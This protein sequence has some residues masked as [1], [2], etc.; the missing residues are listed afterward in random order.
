[1]ELILESN[2]INDYLKSDEIIDYHHPHIQ[3]FARTLSRECKTQIE[4]AEKV[5]EYV[6]DQIAHSGDIDASYVTCSAS[7]V[8]AHRHGVCCAKSH[9]LVAVLRSLNIP[10]GLCYQWLIS[11]DDPEE[12]VIHGLNAIYLKEVGRWIRL[13]ARGNRTGI[14]AE[15]SIEEEKLAWPIRA[16]LGEMDDPMIYRA[17]Q[18]KVVQVLTTYKDRH[19]PERQ[20]VTR[21]RF[22]R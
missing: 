3:N 9:L 13:D 20:W 1:M 4:T 6:R 19:A 2:N 21:P 14:Q 15:F 17:P 8:L 18:E 16:E 7:E 12:L 5:Y 11:D 10:A 22:L